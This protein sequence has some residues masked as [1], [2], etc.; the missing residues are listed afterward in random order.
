MNITKDIE[1]ALAAV[2]DEQKTG[3][4]EWVRAGR[5]L[6]LEIQKQRKFASNNELMRTALGM[7]KDVS[8]ELDDEG[9]WQC[10]HLVVA[11][12]SASLGRDMRKR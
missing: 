12:L 5:V 8:G 9:W 1:A 6:R 4:P 3:K 2:L 7:A 10:R 11:A